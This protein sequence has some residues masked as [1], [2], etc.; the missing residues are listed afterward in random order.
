MEE[1]KILLEMVA[2][3]PEMALWVVIAL[4]AYK[5]VVIGS[6]YGII[7]LAILKIHDWLTKPR[8]FKIGSK[9]INE[10]TAEALQVQIQRIC[11]TG[12][13]HMSDVHKLRDAL[14]VKFSRP[15]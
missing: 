9:A 15:Q 6:I 7:R 8:L 13:Y 4:F 2:S 5:V 10:E 11:S 3:L 14:D 1:L 12:Y